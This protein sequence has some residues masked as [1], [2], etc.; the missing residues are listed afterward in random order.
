MTSIPIAV[1]VAL[2]GDYF[3]VIASVE[4]LDETRVAV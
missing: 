1:D 2:H 3:N 4:V